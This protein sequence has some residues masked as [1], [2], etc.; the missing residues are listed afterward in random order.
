MVK[1]G[2]TYL[3]GVFGLFTILLVLST[4]AGLACSLYLYMITKKINVFDVGSFAISLGILV[5][6]SLAFK[7]RK[8]I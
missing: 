5:T 6:T 3:R 2:N 4:F 7:W 1:E 8:Q